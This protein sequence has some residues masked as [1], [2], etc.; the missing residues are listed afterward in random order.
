MGR[1]SDS[2][3]IPKPKNYEAPPMGGIIHPKYKGIPDE[4]DRYLAIYDYV[5]ERFEFFEK[6]PDIPISRL[7]IEDI[8]DL[9]HDALEY[10]TDEEITVQFKYILQFIKKIY[11]KNSEYTFINDIPEKEYYIETYHIAK[12]R[13]A[14]RTTVWLIYEE[15]EQ[16]KQQMEKELKNKV[17]IFG[18]AVRPETNI[19]AKDYITELIKLDIFRKD[20]LYDKVFKSTTYFGDYNKEY[21]KYKIFKDKIN[22]GIR[23]LEEDEKILNEK[24]KALDEEHKVLMKKLKKKTKGLEEAQHVLEEKQKA[25]D[26]EKADFKIHQA[27]NKKSWLDIVEARKLQMI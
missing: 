7:E 3:G 12:K 26:K 20:D 14:I 19:H 23:K 17:I 11:K 25:L 4:F 1:S 13:H 8:Q 10:Y 16:A 27:E 6:N 2:F 15:M 5:V 21:R 22:D 24:Q 9:C 18:K